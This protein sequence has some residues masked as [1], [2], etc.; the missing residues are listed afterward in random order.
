MLSKNNFAGV[1]AIYRRWSPGWKF[2]SSETE[3]IKESFRLPGRL[4]AALGYYWSFRE[5][6]SRPREE[7]NGTRFSGK[8]ATPTLT[9][10]GENDGALEMSLMKNTKAYFTGEYRYEIVPGSG[11]FL[12]REVPDIVL[13]HIA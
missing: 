12:H 9:L 11:H 4:D 13:D 3:Y 10:V 5:R 2:D 7:N 8:T 1:D 6:R